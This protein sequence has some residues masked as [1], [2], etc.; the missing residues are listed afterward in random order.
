VSPIQPPP[1]SDRLAPVATALF[2]SNNRHI[3]LGRM[4]ESVN[5]VPP[6]RHSL[7]GK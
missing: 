3:D 2:L 1:E 5:F 6:Y 4:F 7:L